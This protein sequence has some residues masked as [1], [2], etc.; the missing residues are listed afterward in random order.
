[1]EAHGMSGGDV[2]HRNESFHLDVAFSTG[3]YRWYKLKPIGQTVE[4]SGDVHSVRSR[5]APA[6]RKPCECLA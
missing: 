6:K 3:A 4:R 2:Y 1:M 5:S